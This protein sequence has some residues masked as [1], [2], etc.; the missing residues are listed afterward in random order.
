[1]RACVA[2]VV[3]ASVFVTA[4]GSAFAFDPA[5]GQP[6]QRFSPPAAVAYFKLPFQAARTEDRVVYGLAL[7]APMPRMSG[8]ASVLIADT[9]KLM[10]L[11]FNGVV[12]DSL[13][14]TGQVAWARNPS[15]QPDDRRLN[16]FGGLGDLVLGLAG[17]AVVAYG[18][19]ALVKKKC[20]AVKTTTGACVQAGN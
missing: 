3:A 13:R 7:T 12:P 11:R 16:L 17:T 5:A 8:A 6:W 1:M 19:Y 18:I 4:C 15:Q 9:P 14:V 2:A 20:P 10:D